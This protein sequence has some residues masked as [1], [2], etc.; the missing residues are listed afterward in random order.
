MPKKKQPDN[1]QEDFLDKIYAALDDPG[2]T[3]M[4]SWN[5]MGTEFEIRDVLGFSSVVLPQYFE[6]SSFP[7]FLK[8]LTSFGFLKE[9]GRYVFSRPDFTRDKKRG[10]PKKS[11]KLTDPVPKATYQQL[12]KRISLLQ[13][14]Q[15][16][17]KNEIASILD[18]HSTFKETNQRLHSELQRF[19]DRS[20]RI[21]Q[22]L[23]RFYTCA[24]FY[25]DSNSLRKYEVEP[26][27]QDPSSPMLTEKV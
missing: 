27:L 21:D 1:L 17:L 3:P 13:R 18:H 24:N 14:R 4:I 12:L 16:A 2:A 9:S 19:R 20:N 11:R 15:S 8:H 6:H 22:V 26:I 7:R 5:E 25:F 23:Y 10:K